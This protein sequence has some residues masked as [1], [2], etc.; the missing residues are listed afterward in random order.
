MA[1]NTAADKAKV[2]VN[3]YRVSG[4][5][6]KTGF[7]K[8]TYTVVICRTRVNSTAPSSGVLLNTPIVNSE[9]CSERSPI[10]TAILPITNAVNIMVCQGRPSYRANAWNK[11]ADMPMTSPNR[12][13][14]KPLPRAN[15]PSSGGLG[16]LFMAFFSTGSAVRAS[17]GRLSVKKIHP[18]YLDRNQGQRQPKKR[19]QKN[20]PQGSGIGCHGVFDKL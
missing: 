8:G 7:K 9:S 18:Q 19:R 1:T 11:R 12:M 10:T 17:P 14:K 2:S 13:I 15:I 6:L 3:S 20:G 4:T 16:G 5:V